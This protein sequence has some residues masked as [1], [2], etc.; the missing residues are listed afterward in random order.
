MR[1]LV[2][3]D[4]VIFAWGPRY[5]A[6]LE[7]QQMKAHLDGNEQLGQ[8]IAGI[9]RSTEHRAFNLFLNMSDEQKAVIRFVLADPTFYGELK[10]KSGSLQALYEMEAAGHL[11]HIVTSPM[12]SNPTCAD[13]KLASIERYLG[14]DWRKR[15]IITDD[16]TVIYGDVLFDDKGNITGS[17]ARP[18]WRQVII[19]MPH[20]RAASEALPR[21]N[22]LA[23]WRVALEY[24]AVIEATEAGK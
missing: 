8:L 12:S 2:D 21:I 22:S 13:S 24:L 6:G 17:M 3:A 10:P 23:D 20:N 4:D 7:A 19:D 18:A 14:S 5:D 9:P 15:T 1:L 11:V 16:K